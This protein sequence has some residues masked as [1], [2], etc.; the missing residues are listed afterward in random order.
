MFTESNPYY[1]D[2]IWQGPDTDQLLL[3]NSK[4]TSIFKWLKKNRKAAKK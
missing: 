2:S 4:S 1:I 3:Y